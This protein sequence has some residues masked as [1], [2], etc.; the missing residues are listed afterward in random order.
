MELVKS[1]VLSENAPAPKSDWEMLR[2]K[3][4]LNKKKKKKK[5]GQPSLVT[6]VKEAVAEADKK[7]RQKIEKE[8]FLIR[9]VTTVSQ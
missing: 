1:I 2:E 6:T 3:Y 8:G 5:K 9:H 4:G 7:P